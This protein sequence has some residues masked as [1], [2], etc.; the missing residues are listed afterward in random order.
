MSPRIWAV[1][2]ARGGSLPEAALETLEEAKRVALALHG[3]LVAIVVPD[4]SDTS[5]WSAECTRYGADAVV[6]LG[7]GTGIPAAAS[8]TAST[9]VDRITADAPLAVLFA[10]TARGIDLGARASALLRRRFADRC[11]RFDIELSGD[12]PTASATR[13]V[14]GGRQHAVE[15]WSRGPFL[16]AMLPGV[17]G[18]GSGD[19]SR[20][21]QPVEAW[22][23]TARAQGETVI[24]AS[25]G[26][27]AE[28]DLRE[29]DVIVAVGRGIGSAEK[30]EAARDLADALSAGLGGSRPVIEAGWLPY[31]RQVGQT[32]RIV[33]PRVYIACGISG[34]TQHLA[35]I[36]G[37]ET[38]IAINSDPS[39]PILARADLGIVGDLN[40]VVPALTRLVRTT[41]DG[42]QAAE[43]AAG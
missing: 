8:A 16:G 23:V 29:C 5:K 1:L 22:A 33:T 28:Q 9:L 39:A 35:G 12:A 32:G 38:V 10:G 25:L 40:D 43:R 6:A 31:E 20:A 3:E 34:A 37:A 42:A 15:R 11:V 30:V 17:V 13:H 24:A 36:Q 14:A 4:A 26:D 19:P 21:A 41:R 18:V 7:T 27:P 2:L